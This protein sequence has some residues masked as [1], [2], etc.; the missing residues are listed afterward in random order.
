MWEREG[1]VSSKLTLRCLAGLVPFKQIANITT[2]AGNGVRALV[3]NMARSC[4]LPI[5]VNMGEEVDKDEDPPTRAT[6]F[7]GE[8]NQLISYV[9]QTFGATSWL[10][11]TNAEIRKWE[12]ADTVP[13]LEYDETNGLV[14]TVQMVQDGI[15]FKV[16]LDARAKPLMQVKLPASVVIRQQQFSPDPFLVAGGEYTIGKV[17]HIGDTRGNDWYSEITAMVHNSELRV[18]MGL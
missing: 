13:E 9:A 2:A 15:N 1:G 4:K 14:G 16:L 18:M 11:N 17:R 12:A 10:G 8:P 3:A 6:T 5:T 7:F